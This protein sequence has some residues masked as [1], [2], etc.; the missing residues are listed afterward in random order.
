MA[1][2]CSGVCR[3]AY[4]GLGMPTRAVVVMVDSAKPR[5]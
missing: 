2:H 1:M 3:C 5:S 4:T